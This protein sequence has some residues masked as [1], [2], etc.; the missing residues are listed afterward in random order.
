[1]ATSEGERLGTKT[2]T[3]RVPGLHRIQQRI[4]E[5]R[6][7]R[8]PPPTPAKYVIVFTI[9]ECKPLKWFRYCPVEVWRWTRSPRQAAVFR[10]Y[11][12]AERAARN[13]SLYWEDH[14]QI[15]KIS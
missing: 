3:R 10:S 1:M 9:G 6:L 7:L 8:Q 13:C 14:Y 2:R 12:S 5:Y 4:L 11:D 15:R